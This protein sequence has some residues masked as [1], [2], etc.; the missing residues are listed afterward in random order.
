MPLRTATKTLN[1]EFTMLTS[2]IRLPKLPPDPRFTVEDI[3]ASSVTTLFPDDAQ[4]Q[5]GDAGSYVIYKSK[6][7]GDLEFWLTDPS[8]DHERQLFA[9]LVWNAGVQMAEYISG[10]A[11]GAE[12]ESWDITGHKVLELGAGM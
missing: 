6:R 5:H 2:L 4:T 7:F 10:L 11:T 12:D 9:H 1:N 8:L 3:Y